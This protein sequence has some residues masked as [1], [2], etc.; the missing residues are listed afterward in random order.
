MVYCTASQLGSEMNLQKG[1]SADGLF[2]NSP[3]V[4]IECSFIG[5][6]K[7]V[8]LKCFQKWPADQFEYHFDAAQGEM[9]HIPSMS[10]YT[11]VRRNLWNTVVID[12]FISWKNQLQFIQT[13]MKLFVFY[14]SIQ[15]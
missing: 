13:K 15:P 5:S 12:R 10:L 7:G 14:V 3:K 1:H 4:Y 11:S 2:Q 6:L 8:L 9:N